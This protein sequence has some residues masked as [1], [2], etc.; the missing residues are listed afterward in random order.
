MKISLIVFSGCLSLS[1]ISNADCLN[2]QQADKICQGD[3]VNAA[4]FILKT[5]KKF[6]VSSKTSET[7]EISTPIQYE[8]RT[9][10]GQ[11]DETVV[12]VKAYA[13]P[14]GSCELGSIVNNLSG[15][16]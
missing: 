2:L 9:S 7:C 1:L 8:F 16:D 14:E 15:N 5:D 12:T 6:Y 4:H 10:S 11:D 3:A 13:Y